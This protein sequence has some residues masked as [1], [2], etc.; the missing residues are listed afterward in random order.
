VSTEIELKL[1]LPADALQAVRTHPA[2]AAAEPAEDRR[3]LDNTYYDTPDLDLRSE[4]MALRIRHTGKRRLQTV[5]C[6]AS[7]LGGLSSRPEWEQAYENDRF[8]FSQID[9][10]A[11]RERLESLRHALT[12]VFTTRFERETLRIRPR[13]GASILVM[14]DNG[15]IEVEG[16]S[17]PLCELELEL[18]TGEAADLFALAIALAQDLPLM[19]EDISKAQRGY[20]LFQKQVAKPRRAAASPVR[21]GMSA[22]DALRAIGFDTLAMWQYNEAHLSDG[23]GGEFLHQARV[24]LRRLRSAFT[25]FSAVLPADAVAAWKPRLARLANALGGARD[26]DVVHHALLEPILASGPVG[27][28]MERLV[29]KV[30]QAREAARNGIDTTPIGSGRGTA[31]LELA[32]FLHALEAPA[33]GESV[34]SLARQ[35]LLS[36]RRKARRALEAA[37]GG[38]VAELHRLRIVLKRLRYGLEFFAPLWPENAV[39][40]YSKP[41]SALQED[42]GDI[43][44]AA[45]G[46]RLLAELAAEDPGLTA[47]RA[48]TAG[49]HAQ[50]V[51]QLR[52][53]AVQRAR[54]LL[55]AAPPWK[56]TK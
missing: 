42:L 35:A 51:A 19:P 15:S 34:E 6:A 48:F 20:A 1:S 24:A 26:A 32:A 37:E 56:K 10:E 2:L 36:T 29:A 4:R 47:A 17:A 12:P 53:R 28:D 43:N 46:N 55:W 30:V 40:A 18:E 5:K 7:S 3:I 44:D 23:D 9:A 38:D 13:E 49:W 50:R 31:M 54:E 25:L 52:Q 45:M 22:I 27:E 16:G 21:H 41:L 33:H 11:V 14:F 8:D 39:A